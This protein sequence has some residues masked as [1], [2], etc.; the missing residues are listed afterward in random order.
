M[1]IQPASTTLNCYGLRYTDCCTLQ[2][3]CDR[4]K[5]LKYCTSSQTTE[6]AV[7]LPHKTIDGWIFNLVFWIWPH[8]YHPA[9][10]GFGETTA[11]ARQRLSDWSTSV[12]ELLTNRHNFSVGHNL[13]RQWSIGTCWRQNCWITDVNCQNHCLLLSFGLLCTEQNTSKWLA[14]NINQMM[15]QWLRNWW[16]LIIIHSYTLMNCISLWWKIQSSKSWCRWMIFE[17]G[18][19]QKFSIHPSVHKTK[20]RLYNSLNK[21][22]HFFYTASGN[23]EGTAYTK[24]L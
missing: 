7:Q 18:V 15:A 14:A 8:F 2:Q 3:A 21:M 5:K 20:R 1:P 19:Q 13:P 9:K 22:D 10:F 11:H 12:T 6:L 4:I 17:Y 16:L 23:M 24:I